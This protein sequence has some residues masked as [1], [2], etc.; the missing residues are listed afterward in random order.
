[1]K[2]LYSP[3]RPTT[4]NQ[5]YHS[6]VPAPQSTSGGF[7][8]PARSSNTNPLG[9]PADYPEP[10]E[11]IVL[12]A[13]KAQS[14]CSHIDD[15]VGTLHRLHFENRHWKGKYLIT[16]KEHF[17]K[18]FTETATGLQAQVLQVGGTWCYGLHR[19]R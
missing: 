8:V 13:T 12:H 19:T 1:M 2:R 6:A 4:Y 10:D 15:L 17:T 14:V 16:K 5:Q 3:H 18:F 7:T 11:K 9:F